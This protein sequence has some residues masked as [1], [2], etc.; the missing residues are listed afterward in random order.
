MERPNVIVLGG[1]NGSGKSTIAKLVLKNELGV[2]DYVNADVIAMGL[3]GFDPDSVALVAG[4]IMVERLEKLGS[5]GAT[6]AVETTLSGKTLAAFIRKLK[7]RHDYRFHLINVWL[8]SPD[9][10]VL[11]VRQ[12]VLLGG[13]DIPEETVRRRYLRSINNCFGLYMPMADSWRVFDNSG[14]DGPVEI[15]YGFG[16]HSPVVVDAVAWSALRSFV[17]V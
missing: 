6:F 14:H 5:A 13:H 15:G 12:R 1:A 11:R 3:S 7:R 16:G 9:L 2:S 10:N 8:C 4:R 17:H